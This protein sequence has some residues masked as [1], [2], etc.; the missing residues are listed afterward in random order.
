MHNRP[1]IG[2]GGGGGKGG[3]GSS[4]QRQA[5]EAPNTLRSISTAQVIDLLCVGPI[6]SIVGG[7]NGISLANTPI[8]DENGTANYS[9]VS[10]AVMKGLPDQDTLPGFPAV[11]NEI[12]V[13]V[14][15]PFTTPV[16]R[17]M[18][19]PDVTSIR[20]TIRIPSLASQDTVTGDINPTSVN[21]TINI[22]PNGGGYSEVVND[23]ISGK[24]NSPYD[25][26]YLINLP[27][28]GAPWDIRVARGTPDS[29]TAALRNETLWLS[30][31]EIV[32]H[33]LIYPGI[34]YCGLIVDSAQF[35][36]IPPRSYEGYWLEISI[37]SNYYP[38]DQAFTNYALTNTTLTSWTISRFSSAAG[39]PCGATGVGLDLTY[40][41][42]SG[43]PFIER[44]FTVPSTTK[45][46]ATIWFRLTADAQAEIRIG[47]TASN[48]AYARI[49]NATGQVYQSGQ[50]G[51]GWTFNDAEITSVGSGWYRLILRATSSTAVT[52]I[53]IRLVVFATSIS[54]G[55]VIGYG[56]AMLST[57]PAFRRFFATG[58]TALAGLAFGQNRT[59]DGLWDGTF[60]QGWSD[61]PA[62]V[63]YTSLT[64]RD[65]GLG[66]RISAAQVDKWGLYDIGRY[67]DELIPDGFG[68]LEPRF[69]FNGGFFSEQGAYDAL[70]FIAS[71]FR[72]MLYWGTGT[73]TA[74]QDSPKDPIKLVTNASVEEGRFTYSGTADS[75]RHSVVFV[76]WNDPAD[77]YRPA[78][79]V[80]QDPE[81]L[82]RYGYRRTSILA[83]GCTSRGQ[84]VRVGRWL[85]YTEGRETEIVSYR[86]GL[87]H[88][89]VRP[90]DV[91]AIL[92][93]DF[94]GV[95]HAGRVAVGSTEALV[96]L[97]APVA[98]D[99]GQRYFLL[100]TSHDGS[101]QERE[102]LNTGLLG[103]EATSI[104][105]VA[106][107][108][109]IPQ[110]NALWLIKA[111]NLAPRSFRVLSVREQEETTFE[112]TAVEYTESKYALI[113]QGLSF[114]EPPFIALPSGPLSPP[115]DLLVDEQLYLDGAILASQVVISW[116]HS[117][118]PRA[119]AYFI[120]GREPGTVGYRK[121]GAT[122]DPYF[123]LRNARDGQWSF[124]VRAGDQ[125][126]GLSPWVTTTTNLL[127]LYQAPSD[128]IGFGLSIIDRIGVLTWSPVREH[129]AISYEVRYSPETDG[130][131]SWQT[132]A[133]LRGDIRTTQFQTA[134]NPG[135]YFIK[136]VSIFGAEST[137]ATSIISQIPYGAYG[138]FVIDVAQHPTWAGTK[139]NITIDS[140]QILPTSLIIP[141][142]YE[143]QSGDIGA[144]LV[145]QVSFVM[146]ATGIRANGFMSA[147]PN[148]A[149]LPSLDS[150]SSSGWDIGVEVATTE[151][152]PALN[153]WSAWEPFAISTYQ[154]RAF[155]IRLTL[156]S[157]DA[158]ATIPI[159]SAFSLKVDVPDRIEGQG[160]LTAPS[161]G[162]LVSF[163]PAFLD[164]PVIQITANN[165]ATGDYFIV[166]N[167][168]ASGF[169]VRFFN[170]GGTGISRNLDWSAQ[171]YGRV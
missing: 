113:E 111:T 133:T 65:W 171:G 104:P 138:N 96:I 82:A 154:A 122:I 136:A 137:N 95:R 51:S 123:I 8:I 162:L 147:W 76:T 124:R 127:G 62:W 126:N 160:G 47:S 165:M 61:N 9:G 89:D 134:P 121:L 2:R 12:G 87:D 59:Y 169:R 37:P 77:S 158:G 74:T 46:V 168:S 14:S 99:I 107:L 11:E 44:A 144:N 71:S 94:A 73:V 24:A 1:L 5:V 109:F 85:L 86:A 28:G 155:K 153:N 102:V 88:A 19:D 131:A 110:P 118:D 7:G 125:L 52:S 41:D 67:C 139:T 129:G 75:A 92:D 72:G 116:Q 57:G 98:F 119:T 68:G 25:R 81:L 60:K 26:S 29:T 40:V 55:A 58:A 106:P 100:V 50:V 146:A 34:A 120:E 13:N 103:Q 166:D 163:S 49:A 141:G 63:L 70:Q 20:V 4:Q 15:I 148:L 161:T 83:P 143:F 140:G 6:A 78:I 64:N 132:A 35:Q 38:F 149:D 48:Y 69:T 159:V 31:T 97:D 93:R 80:V 21:L 36:N 170:S 27:P 145:S 18:S 54:L 17:T 22:R 135:T 10:W 45:A 66:N 114:T 23:T 79:E 42:N 32:D 152:D 115:L 33:K 39:S 101:I 56:G 91:L 157:L 142:V 164:T 108:G 150:T 43:S 117:I 105:L 151:D 156:Y 128:V 130:S 16:V 30:Y 84:A 167:Q 53:G 112:I 3:K 90:G